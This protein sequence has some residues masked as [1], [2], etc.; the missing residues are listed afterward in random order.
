MLDILRKYDMK[1]YNVPLEKTVPAL[2]MGKVGEINVN[3]DIIDIIHGT[4]IQRRIK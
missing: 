4:K 1:T 2:K 3:K